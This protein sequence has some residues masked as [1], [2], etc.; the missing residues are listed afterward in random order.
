MAK[1]IIIGGGVSGLSAGI[2][3]RLSGHSVTICERHAKA[4]GNLTS[5]K[6]GEYE[7]DNCI[8]WLTGTNP[9]SPLYR[10]WVTLGALGDGVDIYQP[11]SLYTC[12]LGEQ[13][14]SLSKNIEKLKCDMLR[15]SP[16]D[17][18]EINSLINSVKLM[19]RLCGIGGDEN[20][21]GLT[22]IRSLKGI[23]SL[24]KCYYLSAKELS[25][26]FKHPLLRSF[27]GAFWGDD[28]GAL[29]PI[30]VFAHFCGKNG[31]IPRFGSRGM[32]ERMTERF[33]SLGGELLLNSEIKKI[34]CEGGKAHSVTLFDGK[35]L[36]TD[37]VVITADPKTVFGSLLD[38]QIPRGIERVYE[39]PRFSR[40]SSVQCA[41]SCDTDALTFRGDLILNISKDSPSF[42]G[43]EKIVLREFSH[44]KSYAPEGKT[45]LQAM[46]FCRESVCRDLI[47]LRKSD[48]AAYTAKKQDFA[49][50]TERTISEKLP[51]LSGKIELLDVWTPATYRRY[52][53]SEIGSYM[54]FTLP[55]KSLPKRKSNRVSGLYNV[56]LATQWQQ[57]PGGLPIAAKGG[58]IAIRTVDKIEAERAEK[59]LGKVPSPT[60]AKSL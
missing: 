39:N 19:Q 18:S 37:Y 40:F 23:S 48:R 12:R 30:C 47:D 56:I 11:D 22:D 25:E 29:A 15:I 24:A 10:E 6:R 60:E 57:C 17:K 58:I 32:A 27:V 35:E 4:G 42:F 13:E 51:E 28:F 1:I 33:K 52:V 41:F 31:G 55:S 26:R 14:I 16:S 7:I 43:A 34:N 54:S 50:A 45:V 53:S 49:E 3:A 9:E 59:N 20:T 21:E 44:E 46:I 5:W 8:H 2:Y 38:V 36:F